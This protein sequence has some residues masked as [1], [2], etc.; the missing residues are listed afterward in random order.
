MINA[1]PLPP[2]HPKTERLPA[3]KRMTICIG[4][5]A[6]DGVVIA[7]DREEGDGYLKNDTGKISVVFKGTVPIGQFAVTGAGTSAN[8]DEAGNLLRNA[9]S[10][11]HDPEVGESEVVSALAKAHRDYYTET[12]LPFDAYPRDERPFYRL[13]IGCDS[14]AFGKRLWSTSELAFNST[15][16]YEAVGSG[17][18]VAKGILSTLYDS[19]PLLY[20]IK[21]AAYVIYKTKISVSNC[22]LGTDIVILRR[23]V[24][25]RLCLEER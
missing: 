15:N 3:R 10:D 11:N 18:T 2:F 24:F 14:A 8:L 13:L 25:S 17:E 4:I 20:A 9:Y 22:G 5:V 19:I 7:A 21:L 23:G 1:K 6:S 12:I 16:D